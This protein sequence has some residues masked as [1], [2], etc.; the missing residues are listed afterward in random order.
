MLAQH[1]VDGIL[2]GAIIALSAIGV[3]FSLN[4]LRFANFSHAELLGWGAYLALLVVVSFAGV[5][6]ALEPFSFGLPLLGALVLAALGTVAIALAVD[7][8][9][10]RPLRLRNAGRLTLVFASFGAG[11]ILRNLLL[12]IWGPQ[13]RY[14]GGELQIALPLAPGVRVKPDQLFVLGVAVVLMI[15]LHLF[16]TRTRV[17]IAM[18]ATAENP[19]LA[20]LT[21]V[22]VGA[23]IAWTWTISAALAAV[24]GVLFGLTVQLRPEMGFNLLLPIL[25]AA[26]LGGTGSPFGA[27]AGGLIVGIA[28]NLSVMVISTGYRAAVPFVILLA[29]LYLKPNGL[30]GGRA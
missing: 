7:R 5:G 26:I 18:R 20:E 30:T 6:P 19:G 2:S 11:L 27:V 23:V 21:G 13:A 4:I 8:L 9:L 15:A 14:Y 25:T 12:L 28:E 17:G 10:F 16:L 22:R 29:V 24:G 3:A 1:L